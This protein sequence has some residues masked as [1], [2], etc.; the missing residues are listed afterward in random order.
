MI[1]YAGAQRL[2]NGQS[3]ELSLSIRARWPLSELPPLKES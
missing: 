1:A 3:S 2:A